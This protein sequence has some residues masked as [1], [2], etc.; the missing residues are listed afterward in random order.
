MA[1]FK[2]CPICGTEFLIDNHARITCSMACGSFWRT[3]GRSRLDALKHDTVAT[4]RGGA[5]RSVGEAQGKAAVAF[6]VIN[7]QR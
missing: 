7:I 1:Q 5:G 2:V 6:P 4:E 3:K